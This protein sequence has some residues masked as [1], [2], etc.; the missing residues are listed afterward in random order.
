MK[1]ATAPRDVTTNAGESAAFTIHDNNKIFH[2]LINGL[3]EDKVGSVTREIW[4]NALDA[5]V[6]AGCPERPFEVTMP[7]LFVP[8]F[9]VRDFGVSLTHDDV[10]HL[11]T[12]LGKSTKE[13]SNEVIG[14][15]GIG[16][17][18]PFAYTDT[19]NIT[20]ILDGVK[21][22]YSAI[23][24]EDG[25]PIIHVMG[26]E[27]TD[28]ETGVEVSF[29][30]HQD[31]IRKFRRAAYRV[32]LGF[33][34]PPVLDNAD[35]EFKGWSTMN[36]LVEG[37]GWKLLGDIPEGFNRG[38]YAKMGPVLYPISASALSDNIDY[39][40]RRFLEH[41][42]IFEFP[43]GAL[44]IA[45]SR[46]ALSY[47]RYEPTT[48]SLVAAIKVAREELAQTFL[49][50]YTAAPTLWEA[51]AEFARDANGNTM[52][53]TVRNDVA[54]RA[55]WHGEKVSTAVTFDLTGIETCWVEGRKLQNKIVR[56]NADWRSRSRVS[57]INP[58][59]SVLIV[60]EDLS[61]PLKRVGER[62]KLYAEGEYNKVLWIKF[63]G[64][65]NQS[66]L[67]STF[68]TRMEGAEVVLASDL[69]VP[70]RPVRERGDYVPVQA[71]EFNGYGFDRKV[72]LSPEEYEAGGFY[73][74]MER[75]E[76]CEY[77]DHSSTRSALTA[78]G[79][80]ESGTRI[81]GVPKTL[82]KRFGGDQWTDF[83]VYA[84]GVLA[85]QK[86]HMNGSLA[87][88]A[89]QQ[90]VGRDDT[91]SYLKKH[92]DVT[93]LSENSAAGDA[94]TF[95]AEVDAYDTTNVRHVVSLSRGVGQS[96]EMPESADDDDFAV[97]KELLDV[98]YPLLGTLHDNWAFNREENSVDKLNQYV[99]MC[100]T[101]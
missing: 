19:F 15:F 68:L 93:G 37:T 94:L 101:I 41:Q 75:G 36:P 99:K 9:K 95:V 82:W 1:T 80:L 56:F 50:K 49:D 66:P 26:N 16:S 63:Y 84:R 89:T 97:H 32:A 88:W 70:E 28:D 24:G 90:Q 76:V 35:D 53:N 34:V 30:V 6:E 52:P 40:D 65:R 61:E 13:G 46:E 18:S 42:F 51:T 31:D 57:D 83:G 69:D 78:M 55:R 29:P 60:I 67:L 47:G 27:D 59:Y 98:T 85:E 48:D 64:G 2:I 11:Y 17:K 4:S 3:Y 92:I 87:L 79:L 21:T 58:T 74:K 96:I 77:M 62:I 54:K 71:R 33:E 86:P 43:M 72:T 39:E 22:F 23:I 38:S 100:D 8:T 12:S 81:I 14:K 44:E 25:T 73:I 7:N 45:A 20:T 5:H 10:M 91:L